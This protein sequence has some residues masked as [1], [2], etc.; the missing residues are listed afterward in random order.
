M[1]KSPADA[2][3]AEFERFV[4]TI[5]ECLNR[6]EDRQVIRAGL[7]HWLDEIGA[8]DIAEQLLVYST[9]TFQQAI[10]GQWPK[11][12][13]P[14]RWIS[15][16]R[17]IASATPMRTLERLELSIRK[18]F[19]EFA[20]QQDA[21]RF[22]ETPPKPGLCPCCERK[23]PDVAQR[24]RNTLYHRDYEESNWLR[25]CGECFDLDN[26]VLND[27]WADYRNGML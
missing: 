11:C 16:G 17:T 13:W 2:L 4:A 3:F 12:D 15:T 25:S 10:K 24:R 27:Q 8:T 26:E 1:H 18:E 14:K 6:F 23:Q 19:R 21:D 20:A 22:C 9:G 5:P 7:A